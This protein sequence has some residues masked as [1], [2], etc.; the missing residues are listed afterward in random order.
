MI[1]AATTPRHDQQATRGVGLSALEGVSVVG[2]VGIVA[3]AVVAISNQ[4]GVGGPITITITSDKVGGVY[5][6]MQ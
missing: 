3:V 5:E 2:S 6:G 1:V 4:G